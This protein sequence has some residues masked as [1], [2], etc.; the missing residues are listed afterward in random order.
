MKKIDIGLIGLAVMGANLARNIANHEFKITVYNRTIDK[1]REFLDQYGSKNLTGAFDL[2]AFVES[3]EKPRKIIIMVKAGKPVDAVIES[4]LPLLEKEDIIIDCG[5]S[6]F[7]DTQ[8]RFEFL[9][10]QGLKFIG[11]GVSGGEEGA[12]NG[13]SMMP[14]GDF[15]SWKSLKGIFESIAA[16]DFSGKPCVAY[17]G[18]NGA[19]HFVKMVHNGIE[20]GVMQMMAEAYDLL[21]SVYK[22][23]APEIGK[24][25][26]QY[27][28]GK[29]KS[30]LF[31][32]S[33]VVLN[34]KDDL[35]SGKYLIDMI[36]DQ[37]AQK[38]TGKWTAI[39]AL[40]RGITLSSITEAVFARTVSSQKEK[41]IKIAKIYEQKFENKNLQLLDNFIKEL[42]NA[43]Y[44]GM[45]S[46]YAQ[47]YDLISTA[48]EEEGWKINLSEISRIWEG[49]CIIRADILNFLHK[50]YSNT[51]SRDALQ[52][53]STKHL[54]EINKI[55]DDLKKSIPDLR[56]I[57]SFCAENSVPTPSLS[58]ALSYFDSM[59]RE[60]LPANFIQGLRDYFGAHTYERI[61]RDGSFHCEWILG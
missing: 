53:V 42:E 11:C 51:P 25:F 10:A 48:A 16:K 55:K 19:G 12:L 34:K 49:G 39:D 46:S 56:K 61:D 22:L 7:K 31:E 43:L 4:L 44:A 60:N 54:F 26:E 1:T 3:L 36:L 45:L 27:N 50:A 57:V 23:S 6:Y 9:K 29:L 18:D 40:D 14:G 20:Y 33:K 17:I 13:P 30:Y 41:R 24:I 2:K 37:A 58:T 59:T 21:R 28:K 35:D 15:E 38:G 47:G 52:C 8:K 5:N 32:I